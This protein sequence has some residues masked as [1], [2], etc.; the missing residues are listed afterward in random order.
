M[1]DDKPRDPNE[2]DPYADIRHLP[3]H[4][5]KK[6][7]RM[8][9]EKRAAQFMPFSAVSGYKEAIAESVRTVQRRIELDEG[10]KEEINRKIQEIVYLT[11][12]IGKQVCVKIEYF[13]PDQRKD[14][15]EYNVITDYVQKING[16]KQEIM[17]GN[18]QIVPIDEILQLKIQK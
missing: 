14:G 15:G 16:Y 5:S 10:E 3:H 7:P 6:H 12:T 11:K 1:L 9:R 13:V 8:P 18:G 2:P 4:E 17:L